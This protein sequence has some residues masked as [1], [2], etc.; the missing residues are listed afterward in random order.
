MPGISIHVVD[1]ASGLLAQGLKVELYSVTPNRS[2]VASGTIGPRGLL[3][4]LRLEQTFAPGYFEAVLH[5]GEFYL[6]EQPQ[7]ARTSSAAP[8]ITFLDL[9]TYRFGIADPTQHY[10]LP[11]KMTAWG[12]SCF[13]GGA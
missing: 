11:F 9:V 2:L 13:R 5:V 7:P 10:H 12:Y 1:V 3:D 8:S 6:T 4:D